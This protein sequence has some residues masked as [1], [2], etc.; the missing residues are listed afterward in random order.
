MK[1]LMSLLMVVGLV[2]VVAGCQSA[3]GDSSVKTKQGAVVGSLL[4]AGAGAIIGHQSDRPLEGA[5]I[6]AGLGALGGAVVGS[7]QD[8]KANAQKNTQP[9]SPTLTPPVAPV[10]P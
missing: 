2:S 1:K 6:G 4:G 8:E 7:A 10:N 9:V 3:P 5:A